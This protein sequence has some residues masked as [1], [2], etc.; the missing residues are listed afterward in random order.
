MNE[1]VA[2]REIQDYI[3]SKRPY[4]NITAIAREVGVSRQAM[5]TFLMDE[6]HLGAISL[7]KLIQIR[8][9]VHSLAE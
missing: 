3:E 1:L 5:F 7:D 8:D 9:F 6:K 4:L 2:K